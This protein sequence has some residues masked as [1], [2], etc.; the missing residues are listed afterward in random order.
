MEL[1]QGYTIKGEYLTGSR[2][3][4]KLHMSLYGL[5]QAS[6]AWNSKLI[7]SILKYGFKQSNSDY[8]LFTMKTHNGDF[9]TILVYVSR[10]GTLF[11]PVTTATMFGSTLIT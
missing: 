8:S 5:K 10:P 2:L 1:P 7:A 11:E 9:I 6:R 3:V 4:C